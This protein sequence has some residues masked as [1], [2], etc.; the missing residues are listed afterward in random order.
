MSKVSTIN[1]RTNLSPLRYPGGKSVL[2]RWIKDLFIHNNL[3]GGTYAE[4]Y[5]GGAGVALFLLFNNLADKIII[6]D[7][8]KSI[9]AIWY[10]ILNETDDFVSK[11]NKTKI[12]LEEWERQKSI[13]ADPDRHSLLE[14]G[15]AA[16]F[17][18]RTNVSG[19]IKG[20]A[21]GGRKQSGKYLIDCRFNR[22]DLSERV[23][24]ISSRKND[25][26]LKNCDA[27]EFVEKV[28]ANLDEKS[29]IYLD[30]PYYE[31]G[32]QLYRNFYSHDDHKLVAE[33]VKKIK[34]PWLLTY[35]NHPEIQELYKECE[36]FDF[37]LRYTA[38]LKKKTIGNELMFFGNIASINKPN[39]IKE[40]NGGN[41]ES[42]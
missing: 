15:F 36:G 20:G 40:L 33:S 32:S 1:K 4:P 2:N 29:L 26:E 16:F 42:Y 12:D 10:S 6:N 7:L 25:I 27:V 38:S 28:G 39:L 31:K 19:I 14:L 5:A 3:I 17:L 35:D 34:T 9:Y 21:I 41:T 8:D 13:I 23:R 22:V 18:N 30:P 37:S 11:I 24:L